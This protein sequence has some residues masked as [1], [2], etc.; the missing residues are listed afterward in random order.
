M[1]K[2]FVY[3][4]LAI[5]LAM[6]GL[7]SVATACDNATFRCNDANGNQ[8]G[9][10]S[11]TCSVQQPLLSDLPRCLPD[12]NL[13]SPAPGL[14]LCKE[15]YPATHEACPLQSWPQSWGFSRCAD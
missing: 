15:K 7:S 1:K 5:V 3:F 9:I 14:S 11:I 6:Y 2:L 8:L 4:F 10:A 13:F 12:F